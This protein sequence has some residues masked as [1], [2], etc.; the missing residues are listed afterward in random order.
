[1]PRPHYAALL[2]T[3]DD[4]DLPGAAARIQGELG[5]R[6][7][8]YGT[9]GFRVDP[10][11]RLL[12][13]DEWEEIERGVAQ[14]VRALARFVADVYGDRRIL[15]AGVMPDHVIPGAEYHEPEMV[16]VDMR[17]SAWLPVSGLDLVRRPD[18]RFAVLEDN[19]RAP[20][21]IAYGSVARE[22]VEHHV[23]PLP[24][25][26]RPFPG[27]A[28]ELLGQAL[29][30]AAPGDGGDPQVVI[31]TDGPDNPAWW[32]QREMAVQLEVPLVT[33]ADLERRGGRLHARLERGLVPVDVV[34]RRTNEDRL[35]DEHG[36]PTTVGAALHEPCRRGT[37]ACVNAFGAGVAD[38]KLVHAYVDEIVRFYLAEE[39]L[40]PSVP[41]HDVTD[42]ET[43]QDVLG[44]LDELVVKPRGEAGG[45][46]VV[47]GPKASAE[48][49][50]EAARGLKADPET[51]VVQDM[52]PLSHHPTLIDGRLEPRH[53]DFR[54]LVM[55]M[56]DGVRTA[57]GG[58]TRVALERGGMKVNMQEN[59]AVKDTWVL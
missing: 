10:V 16:G 12:P 42:P 51:Y 43:R 47:I 57:T 44:R 59:G 26:P 15:G 38:D 52:V 21:G 7:V 20:S 37:L 33:L 58:L 25:A 45:A 28:Y 5:E 27:V 34:Y 14:R 35:R 1:M 32:E 9:S 49:L 31:L 56:R 40:L 41:A 22:V 2:T 11:P 36:R 53:V 6:E 13:A 19:L 3:L 55:F 8:A 50:A 24:G 29:R 18:G 4:A 30:D 46:G 54:P 39:P 48:E 23:S 17:E